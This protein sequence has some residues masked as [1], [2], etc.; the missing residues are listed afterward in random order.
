LIHFWYAAGGSS[1]GTV[2]VKIPRHVAFAGFRYPKASTRGWVFSICPVSG[3]GIQAR[4]G[5]NTRRGAIHWI[6]KVATTDG[7]NQ[8]TT[9]ARIGKILVSP[10]PFT[11]VEAA[12]MAP[13]LSLAGVPGS[14][15]MMERTQG[16][17]GHP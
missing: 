7:K 14:N 5:G 17:D 2:S 16:E 11:A 13:L 8:L 15:R 4:V 10:P 6:H 1:I 9:G 3:A 12:R